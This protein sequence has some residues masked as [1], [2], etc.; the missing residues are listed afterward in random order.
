VHTNNQL[1]ELQILDEKLKELD[2]VF[3]KVEKAEAN[4]KHEKQK[5][6]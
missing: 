1:Q 6:K 2:N 5:V 3:G 4:L